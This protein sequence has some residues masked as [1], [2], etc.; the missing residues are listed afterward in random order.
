MV[1]LGFLIETLYQPRNCGLFLIDNKVDNSTQ[2]WTDHS[3]FPVL[4]SFVASGRL[5]YEFDIFR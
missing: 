2:Q 5:S 4:P 1:F 3:R